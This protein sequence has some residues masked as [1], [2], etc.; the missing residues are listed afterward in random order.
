VR[1]ADGR[2]PATALT[3]R[4]LA[5]FQVSRP[6]DLVREI[7]HGSARPAAIATLAPVV[8]A[9]ADDDD[10]VAIHIIDVAAAEL[11]G[12]ALSVATRLMLRECP[13]I[14]SGGTLLGM[15]RLREGV[16][17]KLAKTLPHAHVRAL[18]VDP[19]VGAVRLALAAAEDRLVLPVYPE[20]W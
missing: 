12:A 8:Q 1:A 18:H 6:Q 3:P 19:A 15:A 4:V 13:I 10:A 17:A 9:A 2:G 7:Y 11:A 16:T 20:T 5:H 14:L